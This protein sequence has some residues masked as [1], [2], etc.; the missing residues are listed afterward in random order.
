MNPTEIEQ[1]KAEL[2]NSIPELIALKERID[3]DNF[4]QKMR[5]IAKGSYDIERRHAEADDLMVQLLKDLGYGEA[6]LIFE[7][8]DKW[9]A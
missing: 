2:I 5:E 7:N 4:T 8:M 9:Y 3:K 1:L 6:A